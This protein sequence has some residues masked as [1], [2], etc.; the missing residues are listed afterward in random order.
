MKRFRIGVLVCVVAAAF[1]VVGCSSASDD[2]DDEPTR[3]PNGDVTQS[4]TGAAATPRAT[5]SSTPAASPPASASPRASATAGSGSGAT[6]EGRSALIES[7][8]KLEKANYHVVYRID[9]SED[10]QPFTGTFALAAKGEKN[11]FLM[12]MDSAD[13]IFALATVDDGEKSYFCLGGEDPDNPGEIDATCFEG[14]D[15][16]GPLGSDD[17]PFLNFEDEIERMAADGEAEVTAVPDRRVGLREAK[18]WEITDDSGTGVAC[19]SKAD[20]FLVLVDGEFD[21]SRVY[22]EVESYTDNP[23][24]SVFTPPYPVESP[25][26]DNG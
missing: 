2:D 21:G 13:G 25:T 7:L 14:D 17:F 6:S 24:D 22:M 1:T 11:L 9:S 23:A 19:V 5:R 10:G 4:A 12:E 16:D 8:N 20:G 18:C 15:D 26:D 3:S